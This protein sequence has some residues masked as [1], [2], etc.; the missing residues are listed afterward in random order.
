MEFKLE[1]Y[2]LGKRTKMVVSL[3]RQ[4]ADTAK[5]EKARDAVINQLMF[6]KYNSEYGYTKKSTWNSN[7]NSYVYGGLMTVNKAQPELCYTEYDYFEVE[8]ARIELQRKN[9]TDIVYNL[10]DS[11]S[12]NLIY[13]NRFLNELICKEIPDAIGVILKS[14]VLDDVDLSDLKNQMEYGANHTHKPLFV[15]Y[16]TLPVCIN[17]TVNH[18]NEPRDPVI[19][20]QTDLKIFNTLILE[21]L[22]EKLSTCCL[23][24]VCPT[25][26]AIGIKDGS[27]NL[28]MSIS[29]ANK[30][31]ELNKLIKQYTKQLIEDTFTNL[32]DICDTYKMSKS[33]LIDELSRAAIT[34]R[35]SYDFN[36]IINVKEALNLN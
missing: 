17:K 30:L 28:L 7:R 21:R 8:V 24:A 12:S 16:N 13:S 14:S 6:K 1:N 19:L 33:T 2:T 20:R 23:K 18:P 15:V 5:E 32:Q 36:V 26:N 31:E 3:P 9:I 34:N 4:V 29:D 27:L 35:S 10:R 11:N 25:R 22:N